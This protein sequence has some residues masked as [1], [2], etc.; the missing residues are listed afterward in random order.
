M[1]T[2]TLEIQRFSEIHE[3]I[4]LKNYIELNW[5]TKKRVIT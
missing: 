3:N 2:D 4:L 1:T 5:K